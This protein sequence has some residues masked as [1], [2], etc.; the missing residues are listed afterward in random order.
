MKYFSTFTGIGGL[1]MGLEESGFECVGFSEIKESSIKIYNSHYPKH[2][3]FG[4]ITKL[5]YKSLPDFDI[6]TGG[7]PC[8]A[9]SMAG[10]RQ[11]FKNKKGVL[12]FYLYEL[13]IA[14]QPKFAVFENVKGLLTHNKGS[15]FINVMQLLG[16]AGYY[17]R[18]LL[19]N[20]V[21]YGSAQNR[22]RLI[23]LCSKTDFPKKVPV[24]KDNTKLFRDVR[25]IDGNFEYVKETEKNLT[26]IQD[27]GQMYSFD[28]IGGYD[29]IGTILTMKYGDQRRPKVI[30]E[31]DGKFR[32]INITEAE[33]LQGF[34][35]D[36]TIM[37]SEINRWF[38]IGN[39][40]NCN[41]SRYLFKE[42]L[43]GLWW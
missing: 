39:A 33:R 15:T 32:Y 29:R 17:V 12:I 5:D 40:V 8:Q 1:D 23:F 37:E 16:K 25:L 14:K 35:D 4:D 11:G 31:K 9:F 34:P 10:A 18:V 28:L 2:K 6:L 19:L 24:I 30:Q 41:V 38:A 3:N 43:K 7:F 27:R 42:Y 13:L 21:N 22:E 36:W 26:R 20:A